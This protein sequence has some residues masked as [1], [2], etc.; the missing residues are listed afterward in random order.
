MGLCRFK[1]ID[2]RMPLLPGKETLKGFK[3]AVNRKVHLLAAA[4]LWTTVGAL[5]IARG[6]GWID[7]ERNFWFVPIAL[8]AGTIK[9]LVIL[10]K[11]ARLGVERITRMQDGTCLGAVYSWK[12]WLLVALMATSGV[13]LRTFF[14]P[15]KY[16]GTIYVAVG[17][18]LLLSSRYGWLGWIRWR[19]N[20]D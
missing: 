4:L 7:P 17:W 18:A 15:G 16:I 9:S 8:I 6:W 2:R 5:L 11:S 3:P 1:D 13:L 19:N 10:D 20:N 14:E 12:T